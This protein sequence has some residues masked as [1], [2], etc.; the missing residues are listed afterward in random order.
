M[1]QTHTQIEALKYIPSPEVWNL[2]CMK[3]APNSSKGPLSHTMLLKL[4]LGVL[5]GVGSA[6]QQTQAVIF[7]RTS[8]VLQAWIYLAAASN[9]KAAEGQRWLSM[10][11]APTPLPKDF[12][13]KTLD[14]RQVCCLLPEANQDRGFDNPICCVLLPAFGP[15]PRRCLSTVV[16]Q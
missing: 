3:A 8:C 16:S 2:G 6:R 4:W 12:K 13:S 5:T 15:P 9:P 1:K 7:A 14:W 11:C 10:S